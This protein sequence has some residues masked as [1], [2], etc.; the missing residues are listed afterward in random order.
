MGREQILRILH[1]SVVESLGDAISARC[2]SFIADE[3]AAGSAAMQMRVCSGGE[4]PL[5]RIRPVRSGA[6]SF[7]SRARIREM[8]LSAEEAR[9]Q[10]EDP[11]KS[12]SRQLHGYGM[13]K[14]VR[15]RMRMTSAHEP[16]IRYSWP[17]T[18]R[19]QA[20][21]VRPS[22][23]KKSGVERRKSDGSTLT[24]Q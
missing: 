5:G 18:M 17:F 23:A 7:Q 14:L 21:S 9:V 20:H 16:R 6:R 2:R 4:C 3:E 8:R 19:T 12:R 11:G 10:E 15:R 1:T 24:T 13:A 22:G